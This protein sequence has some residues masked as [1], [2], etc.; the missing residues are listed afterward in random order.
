M[1]LLLTA[2]S[3]SSHSFM[4]VLF[5]VS[6]SVKKTLATNICL[7]MKCSTCKVLR[8]VWRVWSDS[9]VF[10]I[11]TAAGLLRRTWRVYLFAMNLDFKTEEKGAT[12]CT[13]FC[14]RVC[15]INTTSRVWHD[16]MEWTFRVFQC[17]HQLYLETPCACE[18]LSNGLSTLL[19]CLSIHCCLSCNASFFISICSGFKSISIWL[20]RCSYLK[21]SPLLFVSIFQS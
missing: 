12:P 13:C 10:S 11:N 3:H 1:Y 19:M 4:Q 8:C 2:P 16:V 17:W 14:A 6:T 18:Q 5:N 7:C 20:L 21:V 15:K 9:R